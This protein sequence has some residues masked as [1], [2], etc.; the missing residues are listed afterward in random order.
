MS[1]NNKHFPR[2]LL[3]I[4]NSGT[5]VATPIHKKVQ[6]TAFLCLLVSRL[7]KIRAAPAPSATRVPAM[8]ASS[9]MDRYVFS[10]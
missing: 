4:T 5:V 10:F 1:R 7:P 6:P 9:G 3:M 2:L 8:S